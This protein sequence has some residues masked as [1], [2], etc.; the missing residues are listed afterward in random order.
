MKA[1][2]L[3]LD[4]GSRLPEAH[5]QLERLADDVRARSPG[6]GE[7][8]IAHLEQAPP[9]LEETLAACERERA[10]VVFVLPLFLAPGKHVTH[11]LPDQVARAAERWPGLRV[12][13]L[14]PLGELPGLAEL[15]AASARAHGGGER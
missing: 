3:L 5:A 14:P 15:I 11:D 10:D 6:F 7:V 13:V 2:L 8:R 4:H 12:R 9:S 1:V